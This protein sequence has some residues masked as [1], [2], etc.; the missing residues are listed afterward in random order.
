[1]LKDFKDFILRGNVIELA[2]AFVVGTAFATVVKAL[3][4]DMFTPLLS[5]PGHV[6]FANLHFTVNG[7]TFYYGDFLNTVI[8]F[9]VVAAAMFFLVVRP[10]A[11]V[12]ARLK[13]RQGEAP[14][15][16]KECPECLSTIP[17]LARR[18]SQCTAEQPEVAAA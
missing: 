16:T 10:I 12:T 15:E 9:L 18:C 6:S 7:S 2:I 5:I 17:Y 1:M 8:A 4:T 11:V 14:P 3:V 13:K